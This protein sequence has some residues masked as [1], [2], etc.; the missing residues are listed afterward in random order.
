MFEKKILLNKEMLD[1]KPRVII[2]FLEHKIDD[3]VIKDFLINY[4]AGEEGIAYEFLCAEIEYAKIKLPKDI[5]ISIKEEC[6]DWEV[7]SKYWKKLED[8]IS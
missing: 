1:F 8:L 6:V 4:T 2:C 7:S 5:F 3:N